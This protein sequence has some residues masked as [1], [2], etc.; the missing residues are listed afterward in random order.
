MVV[1]APSSASANSP[2]ARA[3]SATSARE[4]SVSAAAVVDGEQE[5]AGERR[6]LLVGAQRTVE[7]GHDGVRR[8]E[9]SGMAPGERAREHVAHELVPGG[10]QQAGVGQ[11]LGDV[12]ARLGGQ[13]A[14]LEVGA[15]GELDDAVAEAGGDR[16][17][18]ELG[19]RDAAAGQADARQPSVLGWHAA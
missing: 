18:P 12:L 13:A 9:R 4:P 3:I 14:D 5:A 17:V 19:G 16:D 10:G 11:Q 2:L 6:E 1:S 8:R 7:L 15:R